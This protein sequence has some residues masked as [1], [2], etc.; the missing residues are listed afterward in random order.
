MAN[1][2]YLKEFI[3]LRIEVFLGKKKLKILKIVYNFSNIDYNNQMKTKKKKLKLKVKINRHS[4]LFDI[5]LP[6]RAKVEKDL[7]KFS[8][9]VKHKSSTSDTRMDS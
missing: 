5:N 7:T 1:I 3:I 9:K 6:F 4:M 8:R 2:L